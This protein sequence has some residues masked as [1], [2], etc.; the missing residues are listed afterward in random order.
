MKIRGR[1]KDPILRSVTL[2]IDTLSVFILNL[3]HMSELLKLRCDMF[4][5]NT[6]LN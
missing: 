3:M 2:L 6:M 5:S 1:G 4:M